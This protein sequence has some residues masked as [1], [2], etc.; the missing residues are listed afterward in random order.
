M[1]LSQLQY[2]QALQK[3]GNYSRAAKTLGISQPALSLQIKK[4]EEQLGF[5]IVDR[6]K[7]R[8]SIT[9][10]GEIFLSRAK[11]L[12]NENKQLNSL[13]QK[14]RDD[15]NIILKIGIIPT[16]APYL[17]PLFINRMSELHDNI[18][19]HVVELLT[20]EIIDQL[21]SGDLDGGIVATPFSSMITFDIAPLFYEKFLLFVSP[22]HELYSQ[23]EIDVKDIPVSDIRLL[24]EGNCFRDQVNN[25]CETAK[26]GKSKESFYFE[27]NSIESLC[28]IVEFKG[29]ITFLPELTTM[30]INSDREE[31]I[32]PLKGPTK[33]RQIGLIHLPNHLQIH[34]MTLLGEVIKSSLPKNLL[35]RGNAKTI[36]TGLEFGNL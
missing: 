3:Y 13:A 20:E 28:R 36:P 16:L 31:M 4:L 34:S 1:T 10:K 14:L 27:S 30:H 6:S 8:M 19:I 33:V 15:D 22:D 29:G 23:P 18:T 26:R 2:A 9:S 21:I 12:L 25:I 5:Q 24:K 11:L 7:K 32:K 17:L 35:K